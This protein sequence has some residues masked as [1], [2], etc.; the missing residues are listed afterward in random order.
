MMA[1][2]RNLE[3]ADTTSCTC[4]TSWLL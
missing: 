4:C 2:L 1:E 3:T